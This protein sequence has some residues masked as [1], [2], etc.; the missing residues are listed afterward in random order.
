MQV[1]DTMV[2]LEI[3]RFIGVLENFSIVYLMECEKC[4]VLIAYQGQGHACG[5][6]MDVTPEA[7][8]EAEYL[9]TFMATLKKLYT[10]KKFGGAYQ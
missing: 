8:F 6:V 1:R 9:A 3:E 4:G 2:H 5:G 10:L 7:K